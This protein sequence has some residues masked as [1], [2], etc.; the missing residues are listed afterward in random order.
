MCKTWWKL[1]WAEELSFIQKKRK[2]NKVQMYVRS[3]LLICLMAWKVF[4]YH[5]SQKAATISRISGKS[6]WN[7]PLTLMALLFEYFYANLLHFSCFYGVSGFSRLL[8]AKISCFYECFAFKYFYAFYVLCIASKA[9]HINNRQTTNWQIFLKFTI[10]FF[11]IQFLCFL[12]CL[13]QIVF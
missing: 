6:A 1:F 11:A 5:T 2:Q 7:N 12:F 10:T 3:S 9:S 4:W 13:W 8:P